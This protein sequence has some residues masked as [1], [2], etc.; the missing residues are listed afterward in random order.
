MKDYKKQAH[1][2][3]YMQLSLN[4]RQSMIIIKYKGFQKLNRRIIRRVH[5][6]IEDEG[7]YFGNVLR[8]FFFL[9]NMYIRFNGALDHEN[10]L[11][12]QFIAR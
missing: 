5:N 6:F 11:Y 10:R 4:K 7:K 12:E 3:T 1:W 8:I 9:I 2:V